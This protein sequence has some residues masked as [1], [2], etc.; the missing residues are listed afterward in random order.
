MQND[1]KIH[2]SAEV[3]SN[4]IGTGTTV[5]QSVT[6]LSG[7]RIG[8]DVNICAHCFVENDVIIGDRVTIKCGVYLWDGIRLADDVFVG[9]NVTFSN[10]KFPRSKAYPEKFLPT[11][12]EQGAS[13][14]AA[15]VLLPGIVIGQ[16][17]MVGA[18]AVVTRSVPPH[19]IVAG[20]PARIIGYVETAVSQEAAKSVALKTPALSLETRTPVGV[21]GV[22]LHRLKSVHDMRGE[23][24]VGEFS[25]DIPFEPKRYFVVF[26]VPSEKTRG[27]H[28]HYKCHQFLV[29]VRGQCSVVVDDGRVRCEIRLDTPGKGLYLPPLTWGIQYKYSSD[30]M[31]LVFASDFYEANDYIRDYAEFVD[32]TKK[33]STS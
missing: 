24:S 11:M 20:N 23:L 32:I 33:R 3:L 7:A 26:N 12:V 17:A 29:C 4:E 28:A 16:G 30:A 31:L 8:R 9:P 27:E 14:G 25:R 5:W 18:G 22:T 2:P 21:G 6:I 13:I 19:A 15:A 1:V 10:D